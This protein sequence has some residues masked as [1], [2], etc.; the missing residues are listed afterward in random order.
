MARGD[1]TE[2]FVW[3]EELTDEH[4]YQLNELGFPEDEEVDGVSVFGGDQEWRWRVQGLEVHV[5]DGP[6]G[7]SVFPTFEQIE[8]LVRASIE[9]P[10]QS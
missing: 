10:Y 1:G 6:Y 2:F 5:S 9:V 8:A 3:A 4:A 7:D